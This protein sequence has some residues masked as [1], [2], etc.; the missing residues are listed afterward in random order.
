MSGF[1]ARRE[2]TDGSRPVASLIGAD[3]ARAHRLPAFTLL[4]GGDLFDAGGTTPDPKGLDEALATVEQQVTLRDHAGQAGQA[5]RVRADMVRQL[6][7][8][9]ALARRMR[10]AKPVVVDLVDNVAEMVK[11]GYPRSVS[12]HASGLFWDKPDWEYARIAL[13]A[14]RL[15]LDVE[16]T[17]VFHEY[18]HAIH[19]L[20]LTK[21]ERD[22][23]YAALRPVFGHPADMDEVFAIYTEREFLG[24]AGYAALEKKAPGIYGYTRRQWKEDH[25]FAAFVKKL[26]F[27]HKAVKAGDQ[28]RSAHQQWQRFMGG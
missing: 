24:P 10:A 23:I 3:A 18:G 14:D 2:T 25:A 11:R 13:R 5:D 4:E 26:Y 27:P 19:Y 7:G 20:A 21:Q 1:D 16:K 22:L 15:D 8:N 9:P 28:G 12:R 17:L 6:A